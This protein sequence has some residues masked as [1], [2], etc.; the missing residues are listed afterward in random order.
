[1]FKE[2]T[3]GIYIHN[4]KKCTTI[5]LSESNKLDYTSISNTKPIKKNPK[6][7]Y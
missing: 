7:I 4:N 2:F 3:Q 1:M 6:Q 5:H